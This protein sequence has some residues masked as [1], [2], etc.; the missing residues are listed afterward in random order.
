MKGM[1]QL[2]PKANPFLIVMA[3]Y[4]YLCIILVKTMYV[5]KYILKKPTYYP[6]KGEYENYGDFALCFISILVAMDV[7][8]ALTINFVISRIPFLT[9]LNNYSRELGFY[10]LIRPIIFGMTLLAI[11]YLVLYHLND[12][13]SIAS[14]LFGIFIITIA[15]F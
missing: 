5:Y 8:W 14:I 11:S 13:E 1:F 10:A 4:V 15:S 9:F 6:Q 7:I 3:E 12:L 2:Y